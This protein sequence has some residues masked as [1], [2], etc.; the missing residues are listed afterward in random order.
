MG[1][2]GAYEASWSEDR[3]DFHSLQDRRY[4]RALM[5]C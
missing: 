4:T 1:T 5:N 2:F 3:R